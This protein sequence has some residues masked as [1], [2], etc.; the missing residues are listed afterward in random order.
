[1]VKFPEFALKPAAADRPMT[2]E[3]TPDWM[4]GRATFGGLVA[5]AGLAAMRALVPLGRPPRSLHITFVA[6][7][8][9]GPAEVHVALLREGRAASVVEAKVKQG[10]AVC[11][12][13]VGSFG[14]DRPSAVEVTAPA[15]PAGLDREAAVSMPYVE[16]MTPT[17]T[18]HFGMAWGLGKFPFMGDTSGVIGGWCRLKD[19]PSPATHEHVLGLVDAWPPTVLSMLTTPAQG[20]SLNWSI[21]FLDWTPEATADGEWFYRAVTDAAHNGYAHTRA[22]LWDPFGRPAALSAQTVTVFG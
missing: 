6:P 3:A 18:Q 14:A 15:M 22:V 19:D 1:M 13:I 12:A 11:C 7:V 9:P 4:Q 20:S 8:A 16:G 21:Q 5:A 10:G 17:F 2:L